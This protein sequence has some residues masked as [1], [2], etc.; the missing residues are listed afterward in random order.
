MRCEDF[1][2][3]GHE[4]GCCPDHDESGRQTNMRCTCGAVVPLSSRFSL[5]ASCLNDDEDE[6]YEPDRFH[7][8][9]E[10]FYAERDENNDF[11][12]DEDFEDFND[13]DYDGRED[14]WLDG[15][16]EHDGGDY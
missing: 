7:D 13:H 16:Y 6:R 3:C 2:C 10:P 5:C 11:A 4:N 9:G 12:D 15:S 14:S 8:D 1:P